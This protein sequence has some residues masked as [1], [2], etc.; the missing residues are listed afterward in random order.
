[1]NQ[2]LTDQCEAEKNSEILEKYVNF[3]EA[4]NKS[5]NTIKADLVT[6]KKYN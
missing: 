2:N 6:L 4:N 3:R 1:M 5:K